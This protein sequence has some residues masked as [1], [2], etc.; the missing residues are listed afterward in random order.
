MKLICNKRE[1]AQLVIKCYK[2][3]N[4]CTDCALYGVCDG[5]DSIVAFI[6]VVEEGEKGD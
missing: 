6:D 2:N 4:Y 5:Q 1:F 3:E